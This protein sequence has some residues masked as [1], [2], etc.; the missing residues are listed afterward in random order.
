MRGL[1][2]NTIGKN[3]ILH[4]EHCRGIILKNLILDKVEGNGFSFDMRCP[5]C[6]QEQ[7]ISVKIDKSHTIQVESRRES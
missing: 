5:H 7:S 3:I 6:L 4:C 2:N 1:T